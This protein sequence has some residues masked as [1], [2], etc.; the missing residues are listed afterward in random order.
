MI[1][2]LSGRVTEKLPDGVILEVGGI[3]YEVFASVEEL[4][5]I[6]TGTSIQLYIYDHIRED[7]HSLYGFKSLS[8]K[9]LFVQ[10]L[11]VS[12][13]GPKMAMQIL[14]SGEDRLRQAIA[15]GNPALLKGVIGVGTK[16]AERL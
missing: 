13:V 14:S 9:Q 4:V 12:G 11:S 5:K 1:A 6:S 3:G 7:L 8:S 10:L 15:A 2:T 16:T